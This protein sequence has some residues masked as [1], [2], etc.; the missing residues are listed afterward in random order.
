MVFRVAQVEGI[1]IDRNMRLKR[2]L[3]EN[4]YLSAKIKQIQSE[5]G[6]DAVR[7]IFNREE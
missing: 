6:I 3:S 2:L 5:F 4:V 7:E 1:V